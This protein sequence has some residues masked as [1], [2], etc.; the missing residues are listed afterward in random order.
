VWVWHRGIWGKVT[1]GVHG[2]RKIK[3][4]NYFR[5]TTWNRQGDKSPEDGSVKGLNKKIK[6]IKHSH[7]GSLGSLKTN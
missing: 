2:V 5:K 6:E 4:R 1:S 3:T 7:R